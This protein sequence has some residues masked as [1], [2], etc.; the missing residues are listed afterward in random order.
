M[1]IHPLEP[2]G[3]YTTLAGSRGDRVNG[4]RLGAAELNT[5][6]INE[7]SVRTNSIVKSTL[8]I[9]Q[10]YKNLTPW[11]LQTNGVN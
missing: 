3:F 11:D 4:L 2:Q 1:D 9:D 6:G 5:T 7:Y 10:R 8:H